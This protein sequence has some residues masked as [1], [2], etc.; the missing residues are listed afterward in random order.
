MK[1][2]KT[3]FFYVDPDEYENTGKNDIYLNENLKTSKNGKTVKLSSQ[4]VISSLANAILNNNLIYAFKSNNFNEK[5]IQYVFKIKLDEETI[6]EIDVC[7]PSVLQE[8]I[9]SELVSKDIRQFDK[10]TM[11]GQK[12]YK[13]NNNQRLIAALIGLG[14]LVSSCAI[15]SKIAKDS[16]NELDQ[17]T[18]YNLYEEEYKNVMSYPEF[19]KMIT[20]FKENCA[21][22]EQMQSRQY[23][24][25]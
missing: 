21:T 24:K 7:I 5:V 10:A 18:M 25:K 23:S 12:Q 3:K 6:S 20:E 8:G 16:K 15:F 13:S 2:I 9:Y 4:T 11:F 22:T 17:R 14:L 1:N 19:E